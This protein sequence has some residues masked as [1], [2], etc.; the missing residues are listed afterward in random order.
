MC[1]CVCVGGGESGASKKARDTV[2]N[3]ITC[4]NNTV[5]PLQILHEDVLT[6]HQVPEDL[7]NII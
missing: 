1:V 2:K 6:T 3:F 5:E 7:S 4:F